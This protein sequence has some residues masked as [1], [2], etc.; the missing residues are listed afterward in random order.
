VSA[1]ALEAAVAATREALERGDAL[2]AARAVQDGLRACAALAAG[3]E[4]LD[5][6]ARARL[7]GAVAACLE[8]ASKGHARLAG[9]L[10]SAARSRRATDAYGAAAGGP[11]RI[12]PS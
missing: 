7:A 3:G 6:R 2:G 8:R 4:A 12:G 10:S 1:A 9:D 5:L 11:G